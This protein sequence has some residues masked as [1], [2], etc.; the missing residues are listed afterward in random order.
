M[1]LKEDGVCIGPKSRGP[2]APRG[3]PP[4]Y[5]LFGLFLC[6]CSCSKDNPVRAGGYFSIDPQQN[7]LMYNWNAVI[8]RYCD[9]GSFSGNNETVTSMPAWGLRTLNYGTLNL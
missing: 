6:C 7:P 1:E 9:G 8:L 4:R 3:H 5:M 2:V